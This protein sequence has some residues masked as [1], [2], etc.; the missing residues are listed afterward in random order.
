ME[1]SYPATIR[2]NL[3]SLEVT[4]LTNWIEEVEKN[5][6]NGNNRGYFGDGSIMMGESALIPISCI[7][8]VLIRQWRELEDLLL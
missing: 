8:A 6:E 5:I 2:I 4:Y 1:Y 7:S 3:E